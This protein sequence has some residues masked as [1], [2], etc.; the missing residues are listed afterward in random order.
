MPNHSEGV[1]SALDA[2]HRIVSCEDET[3]LAAALAQLPESCTGGGHIELVTAS[4]AEP[5]EPDVCAAAIFC[6]GIQAGELRLAGGGA[7]GA[8]VLPTIARIAGAV[9]SRIRDLQ[10]CRNLNE[11][12]H[13]DRVYFEQLFEASPEAIVVLDGEDRVV[14]VNREFERLFG[15][16]LSEAQGRTINELIVPVEHQESAMALTKNVAAG[17]TVFEEA[18]RRRKDGTLLH[19]SVLGTPVVVQSDQVAVYGIYR[20]ITAQKKAEEALRRLSTTD[21]LTGLFNR[22]GFFLLAE[23]QV[24]LAIRR[25]A[26]LL[27]LYIDIDDFKL[28]NDAHGHVEGDKV[29]NDLA[30][31]LTNCFRDSDIVARVGEEQHGVLA[32]M[33][34]DEFVI[35][36]IDAG[37]QGDRILKDRLRDRVEQYNRES[38]RPYKLSLSVGAVRVEPGP[39]VTVDSLIAAADQ[40]MYVQKKR[41]PIIT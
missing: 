41:D 15:Y 25:S 39:D 28:I 8:A 38:G 27:L 19:V 6:R 29:L 40:L 14:R 22:R 16:T 1:S 20:D 18:S 30:R 34:G 12:L 37:V 35:L 9:L 33:G 36:A 21:E 32:R 3:E 11:G 4:A 10:D 31:I 7:D 2:A 23:Q 17:R 24:R 5:A 26:E 13:L